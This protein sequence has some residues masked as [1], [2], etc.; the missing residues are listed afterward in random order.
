MKTTRWVRPA[1]LA[2]TLAAASAVVVTARQATPAQSGSEGF[3]L[4]SG[5]AGNA[6]LLEGDA[7]PDLLV[8]PGS[9]GV[10]SR[11]LDGVSL[12]ELGSGFPFGP[13]FGSGL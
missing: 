5:A 4:A 11:V 10:P 9:G 2:I 12:Q 13:G 3:M 8:S 7:I 1:I 6:S